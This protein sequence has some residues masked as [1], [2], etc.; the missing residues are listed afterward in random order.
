M[1]KLL[2]LLFG[3]VFIAATAMAQHT[4]TGKVTDEKGN[5]LANVSVIVRGTTTGTTTKED[6]SYSISVPAGARALFFSAVDMSP[7]EKAIGTAAVVN[8]TL[9]NEDRTMTE[10]VV[11][12]FNIKKD[13]KTLGYGVTQLS[14]TELTQAHT[15]NI[16]NA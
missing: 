9:K 4:V 7:V 3:V 6:G 2:L 11:T 14:S 8:A 1:R 5:P 13:K 15:T 10:V 12:A 16:T